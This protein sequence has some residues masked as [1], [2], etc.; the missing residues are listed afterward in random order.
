MSIIADFVDALTT[1]GWPTLDGFTG[2]FDRGGLERSIAERCPDLSDAVDDTI[3]EWW[4][5]AGKAVPTDVVK[6]I[7]PY[8]ETV[9]PYQIAP[10]G[11]ELG[12]LDH[13]LEMVAQRPNLVERGE[14]VFPILTSTHNCM[15][16]LRRSSTSDPWRIWYIDREEDYWRPLQ[17]VWFLN[18]EYASFKDP[19][20]AEIESPTFDEW[21]A[22]IIAGLETGELEI[23]NRGGVDLVDPPEDALEDARYR[24][25]WR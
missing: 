12:D 23:S 1:A 6:A 3:V 5:W 15:F 25:P 22:R 9:L 2:S 8:P 16:G 13:L 11:A 10:D 7:K 19:A 14:L 4:Q 17:R 24:Y 18:N 21:L 20:V